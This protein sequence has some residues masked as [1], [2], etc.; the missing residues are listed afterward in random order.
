MESSA[1]TALY[2]A[3]ATALCTMREARNPAAGSGRDHRRSRPT[4]PSYARSVDPHGASLT[5]ADFTVGLFDDHEADIFRNSGKVV[6]LVNLRD[7]D[8]PLKAF[9]RISKE[10]EAEWTCPDF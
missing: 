4:Q 9:E 3:V 10:T 6:T 2:D 1:G 5:A 8:N 7:I